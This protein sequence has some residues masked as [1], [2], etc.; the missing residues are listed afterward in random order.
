MILLNENIYRGTMWTS[1]QK[2]V[3]KVCIQHLFR[4]AKWMSLME[5]EEAMWHRCDVFWTFIVDLQS[6]YELLCTD[7]SRK[8]HFY[9]FFRW[10]WGST[11]ETS[12]TTTR[13][14]W[15]CLLT[16]AWAKAR[17][18]T[19]LWPESE[20][21]MQT[22]DAMRCSLTTSLQATRMEPSTSMTRWDEGMVLAPDILMDVGIIHICGS[23]IFTIPSIQINKP[24]FAPAIC[25]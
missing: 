14:S 15:T 24:R 25:D 19:L 8:S 17:P 1:G 3:C 20:R 6:K 23:N 10:W 18:Y 12:T 7:T 2:A 21:E 13:S 11:S 16:P 9:L 4:A 22:A 5:L